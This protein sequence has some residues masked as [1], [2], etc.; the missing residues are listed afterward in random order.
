MKFVDEITELGTVY[1]R[2]YERHSTHIKI[3]R[4]NYILVLSTTAT[5]SK[6]IAAEL[7]RR[8]KE[9]PELEKQRDDFKMAADVNHQEYNKLKVVNGEQEKVIEECNE[10]I[11]AMMVALNTSG[12]PW[13]YDTHIENAYAKCKSI[14]S[15]LNNQKQ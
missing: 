11:S 12:V 14:I 3:D 6:G 13:N 15:K 4:V 9:H 7:C 10:A 2:D 5:E 1:D 8:W